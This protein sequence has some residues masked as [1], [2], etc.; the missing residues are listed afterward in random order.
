MSRP[1][2]DT[3]GPRFVSTQ[4]LR[5]LEQLVA[6]QRATEDRSIAD[7][8][9][10]ARKELEPAARRARLVLEDVALRTATQPDLLNP[11]QEVDGG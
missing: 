7:A 1:T 3:I 2:S 4:L 9:E 8:I 5:A 6:A 10:R 11:T